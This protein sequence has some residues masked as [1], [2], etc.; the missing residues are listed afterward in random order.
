MAIEISLSAFGYHVRVTPPEAA[1]WESRS[2]LTATEVMEHLHS[3]GCHQTD[4][5][6]ALNVA[7][8]AWRV[9]HEAEIRR[10]RN[11]ALETLLN[12][13]TDERRPFAEDE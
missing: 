7:N 3:F 1:P 5:M 10:R 9:E 11:A 6:D 13:A 8:P 2:P 12:E 4:V